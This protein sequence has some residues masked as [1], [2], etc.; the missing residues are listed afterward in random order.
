MKLHKIK[1]S[2]IGQS[3]DKR[4]ITKEKVQETQIDI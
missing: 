4:K 1:I 3:K 2:K